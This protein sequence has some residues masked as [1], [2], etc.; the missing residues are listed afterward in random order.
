MSKAFNQVSADAIENIQVDAGLILNSFDPENPAAPLP[1]AIVCATTGGITATC[2]PAFSDFGEDIDNCPNNTKEM[3][4]ITGWDCTFAFT[5]LNM[6]EKTIMLALSAATKSGAKI[7][8]NAQVDAE[9]D[10]NTLWFVSEKVNDEV[11]AIELKNALSTGGFNYKTQKNGK[12]Q[13]TVTL[14]GHISIKDTSVVPMNF[15]VVDVSDII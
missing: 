13:L 7:T 10:F 14:T 8:P 12:G 15:Y 9:T 2:V 6:D 11:V 1:S 3:K 4:R 5:A